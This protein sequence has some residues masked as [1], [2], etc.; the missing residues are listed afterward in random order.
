METPRLTLLED[1]E[2]Q[3]KYPNNKAFPLSLNSNPAPW[4]RVNLLEMVGKAAIVTNEV[5]NGMKT[6]QEGVK[7]MDEIVR[8]IL[9]NE[10]YLTE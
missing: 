5:I 2:I 4:P 8:E 6:P 7:E 10:G 1:P 9:I 3:E